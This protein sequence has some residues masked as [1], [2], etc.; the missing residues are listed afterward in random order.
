MVYKLK[1]SRS[2]ISCNLCY[3]SVSAKSGTSLLTDIKNRGPL[4]YAADNVIS[5]CTFIEGTIRNNKNVLDSK[6]F[7]LCIVSAEKK[8]TEFFN[9]NYFNTSDQGLILTRYISKFYLTI[10]LHHE[11]AMNSRV[12]KYIRKIHSKIILFKHQSVI[13][14]LISK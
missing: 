4:Q 13:L 11:E 10:R 8:Y 3:D 14:Y 9:N 6:F 2:Q 12:S 5:L 1:Q 7:K